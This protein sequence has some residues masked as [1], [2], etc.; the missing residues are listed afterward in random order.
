MALQG[1]AEETKPSPGSLDVGTELAVAVGNPGKTRGEPA[2]AF[3]SG[4]YLVVWREG[5]Y[6]DGGASRIQAV[7][8]GAGGKLLDRQ[9]IMVAADAA[10]VQDHP[11]VAFA[12]GAF[13][14][15]WQ[16][17][18]DGKQYDVRAARVTPG[19]NVLEAKA[20]T[21]AATPEADALPDVAS[22]GKNFMVTWQTAVVSERGAEFQVSAAP[23]SAEG[24]VGETRRFF[25]GYMQRVAWDGRS[26]L[27]HGYGTD[28][29][30]HP[31]DVGVRLDATGKPL[32][33]VPGKLL[34]GLRGIALPERDQLPT[35]LTGLP[36]GGWL[37]VKQRTVPCSFEWN[38]PG[39]VT[40]RR[41]T[42]ECKEAPDQVEYHRSLDKEGNLYSIPKFRLYDDWLAVARN[43]AAAGSPWPTGPLAVCWD[44]K[45]AVAA[46]QRQHIARVVHL[47][48][49][50]LVASRVDGWKA[51]DRPE[52]V[53]AESADEE[54]S[55]A[56]A[57]D[58]AGGVLCVYERRAK[59][60]MVSIGARP[61]TSR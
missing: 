18:T 21:I 40:C 8:V 50:D 35:A 28:D 54:V 34:D 49:S 57:S 33:S 2:V 39:A 38:G 19:G 16:E 20:M 25:R 10:G 61:M 32:E 29:V 48:K 26:Y 17:L 6:G 55:P 31:F 24:K 58:G 52:V 44:G 3:G 9:P 5:W 15:V 37:V 43:P 36:G 1:A 12:S 22:D 45:H 56:V 53:V 47:E 41:L 42:P 27:V 23:V 11:R 60:G 59:D 46:W 13:L 14:V 4:V 30:S 51:L 7:R